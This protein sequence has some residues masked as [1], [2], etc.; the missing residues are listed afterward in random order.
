LFGARQPPV[1]LPV[2]CY[3]I[4]TTEAP[5]TSLDDWF[6]PKAIRIGLPIADHEYEK[7]IYNL[8]HEL[9]HVMLN[10]RRSNWIMESIAAAL[11]LTE[12]TLLSQAWKNPGLDKYR[13]DEEKKHL[14]VLPEP[15]RLAV[16]Q[17][18]WTIVREYLRQNHPTAEQEVSKTYGA[19]RERRAVEMLAA[20]ALLSSTVQ[21]KSFV[22]LADCSSRPISSDLD[23][24]YVH[25]DTSC[26]LKRAPFL[27]RMGVQ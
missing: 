2:I 1:D 13:V 17:G 22:N 7:M 27:S 5:I 18:R 10:P 24:A 21:W 14:D 8:G 19:S 11:S 6:R 9:G 26:V 16:S 20:K 15:I 4:P 3:P 23:F 12:L 25:A